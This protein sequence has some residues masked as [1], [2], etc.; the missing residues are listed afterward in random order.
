MGKITVNYNNQVCFYSVK[1]HFRFMFAKKKIRIRIDV[2]DKS[3][4]SN[5]STYMS[6]L[7]YHM[8][9]ESLSK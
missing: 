9:H 2:L 1:L 3:A 7:H 8:W 5:F 4:K 6:Q